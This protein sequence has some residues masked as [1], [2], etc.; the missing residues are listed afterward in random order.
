MPRAARAAV[1]DEP[2]VEEAPPLLIVELPALTVAPTEAFTAVTVP[3]T[4]ALSVVSP[5]ASS[6]DATVASSSE[7]VA[8]SPA[9]VA[10]AGVSL[11]AIVASVSS[12]LSFAVATVASWCCTVCSSVV[13]ACSSAARELDAVVTRSLSPVLVPN[14]LLATRRKMY[15][16][17]GSRP[18]SVADTCDAVVPEPASTTA[19]LDP[20]ADV[21]PYSNQYFVSDPVG[22]TDPD[23]V[24]LEVSAPD[25]EPVTTV[26]LFAAIVVNVSSTPSL[27]PDEFVATSR[28]S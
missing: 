5:S 9:I 18:V 20:Y 1:D 3:A 15:S 8:L 7:T 28:N 12:R 4:G 25:A 14:L 26:G 10:A 2:A 24:T 19:V 11:D 22:L 6:S 27:V 17:S 16:V 21:V 23:S 13:T